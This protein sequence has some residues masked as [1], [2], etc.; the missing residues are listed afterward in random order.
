MIRG[1]VNDRPAVLGMRRWL[2]VF[3]ECSHD[4]ALEE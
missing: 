1:G 4:E 3:T 2:A